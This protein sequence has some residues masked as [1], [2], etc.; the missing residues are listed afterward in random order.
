MKLNVNT[1]TIKNH[2][3][4]DDRAYRLRELGYDFGELDGVLDLGQLGFDEMGIKSLGLLTKNDNKNPILYHLIDSEEYLI[5][6]LLY[7]DERLLNS[8]FFK[9]KSNFELSHE[10]PLILLG[11]IETI[12][13][14]QNEDEDKFK[15]IENNVIID[16]FG[17]YY[18]VINIII[19]DTEKIL[20]FMHEEKLDIKY[21]IFFEKVLLHELGHWISHELLIG[22]KIWSDMEFFKSSMD[23]KEFWA[24][25]LSYLMMDDEQRLFQKYLAEKY[26][27]VPYQR[28]LE[29][30][31]K[32]S[33]QVL[34]LLSERENLNWKDLSV[35]INSIVYP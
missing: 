34:M 12:N 33:L 1:E 11:D 3:I 17:V 29:A 18:P 21:S 14:I 22:G 30:V 10:I 16:T 5:Y 27:S 25:Y 26:Q 20:R 28:Y 23:V 15:N 13:K 35:K 2:K 31:D 8:I 32:D 19:I 9:I 7:K 24:N 6:P 4:S